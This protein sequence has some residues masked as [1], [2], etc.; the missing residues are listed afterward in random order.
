MTPLPQAL[1]AR[2]CLR[3]VQAEASAAVMQAV[4]MID[5]LRRL[6]ENVTELSARGMHKSTIA[7]PGGA[8][9]P[10]SDNKVCPKGGWCGWDK[11]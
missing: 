6:E 8:Y 9:Q 11:K 7:P 4:Q 2:Q 3:A 10:N 5:G 1:S